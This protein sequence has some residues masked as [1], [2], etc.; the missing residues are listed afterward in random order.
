MTTSKKT[1]ILL[2]QI[3]NILKRAFQNI[4]MLT[5]SQSGVQCHALL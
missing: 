2:E 1:A 3:I 4:K 5:L